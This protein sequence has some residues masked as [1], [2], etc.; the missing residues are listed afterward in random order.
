MTPR[1][2]KTKSVYIKL[3]RDTHEL[4]RRRCIHERRTLADMVTRIVHTTCAPSTDD[5]M[6]SDEP[7]QQEAARAN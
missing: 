1:K 7:A 6:G 5:E 3:D 4:L 2:R